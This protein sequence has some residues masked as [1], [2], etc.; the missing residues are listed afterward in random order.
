MTCIY[1]LITQA[2]K[3]LIQDQEHGNMRPSQLLR[4]MRRLAG[5]EIN[6]NI[7]ESIWMSRLPSNMRVVIF[8]S[9]EPL[10]KLA[11]PH[12]YAINY[13]TTAGSN[14]KINRSHKGKYQSPI[15]IPKSVSFF[16]TLSHTQRRLT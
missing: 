1:R 10:D 11:H 15:Q 5:S 13:R 14:H 3:K 9:N 8:I 2:H 16:I 4:E 7:L 12:T 6:E